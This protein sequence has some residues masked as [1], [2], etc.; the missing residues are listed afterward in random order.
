[1]DIE[2]H[3]GS[4]QDVGMTIECNPRMLDED[5]AFRAMQAYLEA[6]WNRRLRA[7]DDIAMLLSNL[8]SDPAAPEDWRT[9]VKQTIG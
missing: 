2:Q 6:Y 4:C 1:M 3:L 9:A 8:Q 7:S 5:T